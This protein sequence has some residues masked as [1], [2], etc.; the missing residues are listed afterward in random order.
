MVALVG[1]LPGLPDGLLLLSDELRMVAFYSYMEQ[2]GFQ[3]YDDFNTVYPPLFIR[4][5]K[6]FPMSASS[7][8]KA[9]PLVSH[10]SS[11]TFCL[12]V[13]VMKRFTSLNIAAFAAFLIVITQIPHRSSCRTTII[14]F[15]APCSLSAA[16]YVVYFDC[17]PNE[18]RALTLAAALAAFCALFIFA[19]QNIGV[20]LSFGV[21]IAYSRRRDKES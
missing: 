14:Y 20:L 17:K 11:S 12:A 4:L 13:Y 8:G 7:R 19:K 21:L 1:L 6:S 2:N 9:S 18:R 5:I 3:V 15:S 16:I 10:G